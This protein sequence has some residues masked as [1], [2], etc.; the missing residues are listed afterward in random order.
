MW[1]C[2]DGHIW[3]SSLLCLKKKPKKNC[4][5]TKTTFC[6][7]SIHL[8]IVGWNFV[9]AKVQYQ[10]ACAVSQA[11]GEC[12][13]LIGIFWKQ[14]GRGQGGQE[15]KGHGWSANERLHSDKFYI[16]SCALL[17]IVYERV[18]NPQNKSLETMKSK[19]LMNPLFTEELGKVKKW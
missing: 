6:F 7:I 3:L 8:P 4:V 15:R 19:E 9:R 2:S 5:K 11:A 16:A 17:N 13:L 14:I 18:S 10:L 1:C 12:F